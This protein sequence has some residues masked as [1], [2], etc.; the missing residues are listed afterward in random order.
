MK[1]ENVF[2]LASI[3][4]QITA[5]AILMLEEQGKLSGLDMNLFSSNLVMG[6]VGGRLVEA[7]RH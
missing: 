6:R 1:P 5:V 2:E 4:K 3:T 7:D